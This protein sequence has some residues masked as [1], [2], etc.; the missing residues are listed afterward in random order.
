MTEPNARIPGYIF[1]K[2]PDELT[3]P[4]RI[5]TEFRSPGSKYV[6]KKT[7]ECES[8]IVIMEKVTGAVRTKGEPADFLEKKTGSMETA[9][10]RDMNGVLELM[11][12][13]VTGFVKRISGDDYKRYTF[14]FLNVLTMFL[15]ASGIS[16]EEISIEVSAELMNEHR[17]LMEEYKKMAKKG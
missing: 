15:R 6:D 12:G 7:R 2:E 4:V 13:A 11:A 8:A 3:C 17:A 9:G 10:F 1:Q 16:T 5:T 14:N